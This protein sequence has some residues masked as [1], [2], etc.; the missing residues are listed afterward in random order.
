MQHSIFKSIIMGVLVGGVL[1]V[2]SMILFR[3]LF[4]LLIA[5]LIVKA[6]SRHK[7]RRYAQNRFYQASNEEDVYEPFHQNPAYAWASAQQH[8]NPFHRNEE[9]P[10]PIIID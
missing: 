10:R 3:V 7:M 2:A 6:F 1:F 4:F 9:A 5:G 8:R